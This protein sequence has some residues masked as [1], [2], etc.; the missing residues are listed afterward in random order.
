MEAR[1]LKA[2][3][4]RYLLDRISTKLPT[5]YPDNPFSKLIKLPEMMGLDSANILGN[6]IAGPP[7]L[8]WRK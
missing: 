2:G 8:F 1:E 7:S 5:S 3:I 6:F 4:A